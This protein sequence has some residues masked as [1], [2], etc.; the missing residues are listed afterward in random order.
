MLSELDL[1]QVALH[2]GFY[3]NE[4]LRIMTVGVEHSDKVFFIC[5]ICLLEPFDDLLIT[6]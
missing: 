3:A 1:Y 5:I 2:D 6:T 4:L